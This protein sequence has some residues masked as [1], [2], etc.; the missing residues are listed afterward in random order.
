MSNPVVLPVIY[1]GHEVVQSLIQKVSV[2]CFIRF[3][4]HAF[5]SFDTSGQISLC[6]LIIAL[7]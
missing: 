7:L 6:L 1:A 5:C 2:H 4:Q 3:L